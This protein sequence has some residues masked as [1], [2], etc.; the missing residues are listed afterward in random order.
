MRATGIGISSLL[1]FEGENELKL[2]PAP[3]TKQ[4][5]S[6]AQELNNSHQQHQKAARVNPRKG[7]LIIR[8]LSFK[9]TEASIREAFAKHGEL[10]EVNILKKPNGQMVGCA[11]IQYNK[12][13][14]A[15]KAILKM[16]AEPFLGRPIAVDW[17]VPKEVFKG[18]GVDVG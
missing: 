9:A 10:A 17:A 13:N 3:D 2:R 8:N 15:A 5:N 12:T 18:E 11:F 6:T 14:H 4:A 1:V 16:N 7:R